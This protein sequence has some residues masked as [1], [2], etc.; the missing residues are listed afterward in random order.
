MAWML[1]P[2]EHGLVPSATSVAEGTQPPPGNLYLTDAEYEERSTWVWDAQQN[3]LRPPTDA[4][5]LIVVKRRKRR[6]LTLAAQD[7]C[8][9]L[10]P[11]V[12]DIGGAWVAEALFVIATN[13]ASTRNLLRDIVQKRRDLF[14][15]LANATTL[16]QAEAV[17]W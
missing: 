3:V 15:Q 14:T 17:R 5:R 10:F 7:A 1:G 6:E 4:D 11:D 13:D 9:K 8:A 12:A 16:A 2:L